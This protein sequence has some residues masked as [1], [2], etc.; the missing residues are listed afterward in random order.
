MLHSARRERSIAGRAIL[1]GHCNRYG[2]ASSIASN[3]LAWEKFIQSNATR[4]TN[5][6]KAFCNGTWR[7]SSQE[8]RRLVLYSVTCT[9]INGGLSGVITGCGRRFLTGPMISVHRCLLCVWRTS[10]IR[11][12]Y[13]YRRLG[14]SPCGSPQGRPP[15]GLGRMGSSYVFS[16]AASAEGSVY[17]VVLAYIR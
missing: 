17:A 2:N 11:Y 4:P 16:A 12:R 1:I 13:S 7:R 10:W 8:R 6:T 15:L 9:T 3:E 5:A 14:V